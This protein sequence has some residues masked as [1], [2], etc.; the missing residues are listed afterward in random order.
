MMQHPIRMTAAALALVL[1]A[2]CSAPAASSAV[3]A[4][5]TSASS[6]VSSAAS[7]AMDQVAGSGDMAAPQTVGE[8]DMTPVTAD[9]LADGVYD[10]TVDSSSSMFRITACTLAVTDGRMTAKMTMGGTGYKCVYMGTAAEA[11]EDNGA[12]TIA[13][14]ENADGTH[15]FTVPV[16][17]L[18]QPLDCAAFSAKKEKWYDRQILF[19]A[20]SLP[21]EAWRASRV[22]TAADLGLADGSYTVEAALAGG[23]G[24]A[25]VESPARLRVE[26]GQVFV[27]LVWNSPNYDYMKVDGTQYFPLQTEGNATFEIPAAGFDGPL[28]I[29]ADTVAM[30]TPHEIDYTLT[31]DSA[32]LQQVGA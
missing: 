22:T 12:N 8:P 31:L 14:T 23:S 3:S 24:R 32:T 27:T 21:A 13:Y 10:V 18:D 11:A 17:A 5:S 29:T 30:S 20:D 28:A 15:S 16:V 1:L 25:S 2:G 4:A 19:R 26:N 9:Q 7:A 6:A